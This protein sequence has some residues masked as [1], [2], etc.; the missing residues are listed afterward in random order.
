M[1]TLYSTLLGIHLVFTAI[2]PQRGGGVLFYLFWLQTYS[3][4]NVTIA[5]K[6]I[7]QNLALT[8][9]NSVNVKCERKKKAIIIKGTL[10][11]K[12][13]QRYLKDVPLIFL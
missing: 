12:K 4:P 3:L 9:L 7:A 10:E 2:N 11:D 13:I 6:A 5:K 1:A 8:C